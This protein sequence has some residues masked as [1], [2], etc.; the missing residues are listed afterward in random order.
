[1]QPTSLQLASMT[2]TG[3]LSE[4]QCYEEQINYGAECYNATPPRTSI[5]KGSSSFVTAEKVIYI[6]NE[7]KYSTHI[8][9]HSPTSFLPSQSFG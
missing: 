7:I 8:L 9:S 3:T 4:L 6:E 2:L 1:M 5:A